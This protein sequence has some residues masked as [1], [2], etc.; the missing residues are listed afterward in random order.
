MLPKLAVVYNQVTLPLQ[1]LAT[2]L[3]GAMLAIAGFAVLR[4][5]NI[6]TVA[7]H[8]IEVVE[9]CNGIRYLLPLAF[10][11]LV[12]AYTT[13]AA[14]WIRYAV[15]AASVPVAILANAVR[16]AFSGLS[17]RLSE[18]SAHAALGLIIFVLSLALL[19][20]ISKLLAGYNRICK[21]PTSLS[22]EPDTT[23]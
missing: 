15:L 14:I 4:D 3:A 20:G 21:I 1:L 6:L 10:L 9:A 2:R 19:G 7:G 17:P 8:S 5:G 22:S 13:G 12:I 23:A 16:V 11:G 18:G